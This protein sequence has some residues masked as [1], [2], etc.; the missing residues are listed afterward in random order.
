MYWEELF[1]SI[2][3]I[4]SKSILEIAPGYKLKVGKGLENLSYVGTYQVV[5]LDQSA[6][7][8]ISK[9]YGALFPNALI[10]TEQANIN[11]YIPK[12]DFDML[13]AN[14]PLD[15]IILS[16][17]IENQSGD[18]SSFCSCDKTAVLTK[19]AQVWKSTDEL[20]LTQ[21][22]NQSLESICSL[23]S[24]TNPDSIIFSNYPSGSFTQLGLSEPYYWSEKLL[25]VLGP[26]LSITY[27]VSIKTYANNSTFEGGW[28]FCQK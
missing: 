6:L 3:A 15:D 8:Y 4:S 11:T 25:E 5:D 7:D 22:V 9:G 1:K 21:A 10:L 23:I 19:I 20:T 18:F 14:H 16:C 26:K 24:Q 12:M 2:P 28:L 27:D 13:V 17:I